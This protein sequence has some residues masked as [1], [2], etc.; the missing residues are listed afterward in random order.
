[1]ELKTESDP[2]LTEIRSPREPATLTQL[3]DCLND[4]LAAEWASIIR[5]THQSSLMI[6]A[7]GSEVREFLSREIAEEFA[8][9]KFLTDVIA[10]LGGDPTTAP[11]SFENPAGLRD[12]LELDL[13]LEL[14]D[15]QNY[16]EHSQMADDL[17]ETELKTRLESMAADE[18]R[19]ASQ[20]RHILSGLGNGQ[21]S[22]RGETYAWKKA[23]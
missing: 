10:D 15:A 19:H 6:G 4:D 22:P 21:Y 11:R 20:L 5:Y 1:M 14:E 2:T 12:M 9:A 3:I 13:R 23:S 17:Y 8:H 16:M 7:R 18:L